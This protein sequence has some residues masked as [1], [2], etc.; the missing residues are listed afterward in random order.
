MPSRVQRHCLE[1]P[2]FF[3][4]LHGAFA[5]L[6]VHASAALS[7]ACCGNFIDDFFEGVGVAFKGARDCEIAEGP[8]TDMHHFGRFIRAEVEVVGVGED[9]A[10]ATDALAV[11]R[12]VERRQ[13]DVLAE[14][15]VPHVELGP[16]V[17][18]EDAEV[19][20]GRVHAVEQVPQL[21]TLVL[22]VPL[23]EVVAVGE[24]AFLGA[25]FFLVA[26][27]PTDAGIKLVFFD[28]VDEG[29]GLEAVAARV[30]AGFF[31]DFSGVDGGLNA[32]D[33]EAGAESF[34]QVVSGFNRFR[35]VVSSVD[36]DQWHGDAAWGE[37]LGRKVGHDNAILSS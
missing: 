28:G 32:A 33:D 35:E 4:V 19:L 31:L 17:Q 16:V 7:N 8:E 34:D 21:G 5:A 24:E 29:R 18:R 11:M 6:V 1:I 36:V 13:G 15:V 9:L 37:S 10:C 23:A 26:A 14:D 2:F 27:G 22:G 30:G 20:A 12:E 25:G 3:A